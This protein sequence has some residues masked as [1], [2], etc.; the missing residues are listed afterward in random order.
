MSPR[1]TCHQFGG[2][3]AGAFGPLA[4]I[5][6][7][8]CS[9]L[10]TLIRLVSQERNSNI[11]AASPTPVAVANGLRRIGADIATWRRLRRLTEEQVADRAGVS[12][13]TVLRIERGDGATLENILRVA[14]AV[15]ALDLLTNALD[16]YKTDIGRLRAEEALPKRVR[17]AKPG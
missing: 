17:Q 2:K 7:D 9:K 8:Q 10:A 5:G 3:L 14:R 11:M 15:G 1:V 13:H 12:R 6:D 16:P 4:P